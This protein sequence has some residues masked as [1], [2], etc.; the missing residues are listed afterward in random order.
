MS[1]YIY[2]YIN[3]Y[4][5]KSTYALVG[6][7]GHPHGARRLVEELRMD[8]AIREIQ[9]EVERPLGRARYT[10]APHLSRID[11]VPSKSANCKV[12]FI[13]YNS[14]RTPRDTCPHIYM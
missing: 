11:V 10:K 2:Q 4:S 13:L 12:Y 7:H 1:M 9:H 8:V 14:A 5:Y 3:I 6:V